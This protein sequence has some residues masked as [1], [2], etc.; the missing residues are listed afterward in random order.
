MG[1]GC[2]KKAGGNA[3]GAKKYRV[4]LLDGTTKTYLLE[5]DARNAPNRDT[6]KAIEVVRA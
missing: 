5:R 2:G 6:S 4:T 1:C 3:A